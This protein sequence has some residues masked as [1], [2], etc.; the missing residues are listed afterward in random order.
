MRLWRISRHRG[1]TGAGGTFSDSRWHHAP[2]HVLFAAEHPALAALEIL[3]H[4]H[5]ALERMPTSLRLFAIEIKPRASI[6][7]PP[8]LPTGWQANEPTTRALG[9]RWLE[10]DN[11]LLLKVPSAILPYSFNYLINARHR[12]ARTHVVESD[13]GPFWIDP[14]LAGAARS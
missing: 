6:R 2:R 5:V 12:Q 7:L 11:S 10:S 14:R 1:L 8:E 9:D 4:M 3:A 13:C